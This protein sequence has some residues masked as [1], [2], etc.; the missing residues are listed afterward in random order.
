MS[1]DTI[2]AV[3]DL[4]TTGTTVKNGDRI[5]Q[6]GCAFVQNSQ[7]IATINQLINPDRPVPAAI[8]RLTHLHPD[9]L[10]AAPY[11]AEVAPD[12]AKKLTDTVIVAHNVNFDYPFL[13]AEFERV[14]L[15]A[16]T[17]PAI[18]TV[19][20]AQ[21]LLPTQGSYRL[22]D[23]TAAL[24]ITHLNPHRADSDAI[25][26]AH[27]FNTLT[28]KFQALPTSIQ[29]L[30][31]HLSGHLARQTGQFLAAQLQSGVT[32]ASDQ[33]QVGELVLKRLPQPLE[34]L[35]Q[36]YYP[37]TDKAKRA[38]LAP[39]FKLRAAQARMM[40]AI[41]HNATT[42]KQPLLIEAGTGLGKTMGYLLP[43]A[44]VV[45]TTQQL[46][47]TTATTVLQQQV[48]DQ[49]QTVAALCDL[50][51]AAVV[52]KSPRHYLN[53]AEFHTALEVPD[54]DRLTRLLEMKL[55]VWLTQTTT[56]DLEELR[57]TNYRAPL[58]NKVS[59]NGNQ[60]GAS[61]GPW[62]QYDFYARLQTR[63][64]QS[65]IIITNHAYLAHHVEAL[66]AKRPYLVVDEAQHFAGH[67][68]AAEAQRIAFAKL[69][70]HLQR[71][72]K[73]I[74]HP[75]KNSLLAIY[76]HSKVNTYQLQSLATAVAATIATIEST[77]QRL[78]KRF[79]PTL[80]EGFHEQTLIDTD[81]AWL[82]ADLARVIPKLNAQLD[83]VVAVGN[84]LA[85]DFTSHP[86]RFTRD[87]AALFQAL[88]AVVAAITTTAQDLPAV[89]LDALADGRNGVCRLQLTN[90]RDV[91][92]LQIAW[93]RFDV[94]D[95][96]H[97]MLAKFVAPVIVGATLVVDRS[98]A[99]LTKQLGLPAD[100]PSLQL[101][102]PFHYKQQAQLFVDPQAPE[103]NGDEGEYLNYLVAAISKLAEGKHQTIALFTSLK[104]IAAVYARLAKLP[105]AGNKEILAQGVTGSAEKIAKRFALGDNSLLL[106]AASFFEGIDYPDKQLEMVIL[107][108]LPFDAPQA[109]LTWAKHQQLEAQG[110]DAFTAD[111][112]PIAA[113]RLRQSFGRLIRTEHDR[114]VFV[115]LDSRLV[116]TKYGRQLQHA[117][118][119]LKPMQLDVT[120]ITRY[121][122]AWLNHQPLNHSK[123]DSHA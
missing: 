76:A 9:D 72:A 64:T 11:F 67:V 104:M 108:R 73:L 119:N 93:D 85:T 26:T 32:P 107:T 92:S 41:Y 50:P 77:Q 111:A 121:A 39:R 40:D 89:D 30:L 47:V 52:V 28:A 7:V 87:D 46:V 90:G 75:G 122:H 21:I 8:Q 6:I 103:P 2:Y 100:T 70:K 5:I 1:S 55:V 12:L 63:I 109:P 35:A 112:L 27:L 95:R 91:F 44:F 31:V 71:L 22:S 123:E 102:S 59:H 116:T 4:E 74:D 62:R 20:L 49:V 56:G 82:A 106:G 58:F 105:I 79:C 54:A 114:G 45:D 80:P 97:A 42:T 78:F 16:L 34:S 68:A 84:Q 98:F 29:K 66:A 25:S 57:L 60:A 65:Q 69:R 17:N 81:A 86:E 117:L 18:D 33:V 83:A 13:S 48:F 23:L 19:E 51:L 61:N 3:L 36:R 96:V 115:C 88:V 110:I 118:P 120:T 101:R 38:L 14:G 15:P 37:L 53:L 113:I 10:V 43:Y 94:A 24:N 99:F